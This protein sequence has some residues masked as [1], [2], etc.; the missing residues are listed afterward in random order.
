MTASLPIEEE[1]FNLVIA[2]KNDSEILSATTPIDN[3]FIE[4]EEEESKRKL[5]Q[6]LSFTSPLKNC[7]AMRTSCSKMSAGSANDALVA[8]AAAVYRGDQAQFNFGGGDHL[9]CYAE[10][11]VSPFRGGTN[12]SRISH[13][14]NKMNGGHLLSARSLCLLSSAKGAADAHRFFEEFMDSQS[15]VVHDFAK[16]LLTTEF[17]TP[18]AAAAVTAAATVA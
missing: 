17:A 9:K 3:K 13:L 15:V 12:I 16:N 18:A 8:A 1:R 6:Q 5:S 2:I 14:H 11:F 10:S 7:A 4:E